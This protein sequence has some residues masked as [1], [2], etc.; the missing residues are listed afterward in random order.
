MTPS[1]LTA[2]NPEFMRHVWLELSLHRM[3]G[4]PIIIGLLC[5]M[6]WYMDNGP[7][8]FS[9]VSK[10]VMLIAPWFIVWGSHLA[11]ES[12]LGE[13]RGQT[14]HAQRMSALSPWQLV[15]GKL[16]G[17]TLFTWYGVIWCLLI[18]LSVSSE[19]WPL[20]AALALFVVLAGLLLQ[21]LT[22]LF[23][24]RSI[25]RMGLSGRNQSFPYVILVL[26]MLAPWFVGALAN[27]N[28]PAL[29]N[30]MEIPKT[31]FI[32]ASALLF[33]AWALLGLY[34]LMRVELQMRQGFIVWLVFE[35]FLMVYMAGFFVDVAFLNLHDPWSVTLAIAFLLAV[36]I[37]YLMFFLEDTTAL[38]IKRGL[39]ALRAAN[40]KELVQLI[41]CWL[42][43]LALALLVLPF[44]LIS[45]Q[46]LE[47]ANSVFFLLS[48]LLF[49]V[50][51]FILLL[52]VRF[53]P[54]FKPSNRVAMVVYL[55]CSY[56]I[57]PAIFF[58]AN[59]QEWLALFLLPLPEQAYP[60]I[61]WPILLLEIGAAYWLLLRRWQQVSD[62]S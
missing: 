53:R 2:K 36:T 47:L 10:M 44:F 26:L 54:H 50:R 31:I 3:I 12:L 40:G 37:A 46:L 28:T 13:V 32:N 41:P 1:V 5:L 24:L 60:L 23:S 49:A 27:I 57:L 55:T 7:N 58:A 39:I 34:R 59:T 4:L 6:V 21:A 20:R 25:N 22:L 56:S 17:S 61:Q 52:W 43:S 33:L 62:V 8:D 48:L 42:V 30:G 14:W 11:S 18:Y 16:L 38:D 45:S 19:A 9:G 51:D 29:W 35:L 15:W